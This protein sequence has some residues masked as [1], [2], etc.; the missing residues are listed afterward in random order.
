MNLKQ[1]PLTTQQLLL[2][3]SMQ[4]ALCILQ[5]P[6]LEL[7]SY[8]ENELMENPLV[9]LDSIDAKVKGPSVNSQKQNNQSDRSDNWHENIEAES[10]LF[11]HYMKQVHLTFSSKKDL[12]IAEQLLG[13]V[14]E[15][16][17]LEEIP[18]VLIEFF[19]ASCIN[20]VLHQIQNMDPPGICARSQ[21]ES[22][23]IQLKNQGKD[24]SLCY[25]IIQNFYIELLE[26]K[27]SLIEKKC[28][29]P[30]K[31]I[32]KEIKKEISLLDPFPGLRFSRGIAQPITADIIIEENDGLWEIIVNDSYLPSFKIT[33]QYDSIYQNLS[34]EDRRFFSKYCNTARWIQRSLQKRKKT[35]HAL[36]LFLVK[37]HKSFFSE[38]GGILEPLT[39]VEVAA[40]LELCESTIARAVSGKYLSC[41]HGIFPLKYFFSGKSSQDSSAFASSSAKELLQKII[42]SE[43]KESPLSDQDIAKEMKRMGFCCARRTITKYR[44]FLR[45]APASKRKL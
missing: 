34:S 39:L 14:D 1:S 19:S 22:L 7:A 8:L 15:K 25:F 11:T 35:L 28:G 45:I 29:V 33:A 44:K 30:A 6:V 17:L 23:L 12:W 40:E 5:L 20:N 43:S 37:K 36:A 18:E 31:Q 3:L 32:K 24:H 41:P 42:R 4:K 21:K 38:A 16:G 27:F 9:E 10:S 2:S 13:S 26:Q